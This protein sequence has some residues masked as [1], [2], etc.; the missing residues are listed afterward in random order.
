MRCAADDVEP[1]LPQHAH[2]LE[3]LGDG[4]HAVIEAGQ[5]VAVE[6]DEAHGRTI[7]TQKAAQMHDGVNTR[8]DNSV[9]FSLNE[10]HSLEAERIAEEAAEETA[11]LVAI[12]R[13]R[14]EAEAQAREVVETERLRLELT[15]KVE[16]DTRERVRREA[17]IRLIEAEARLEQEAQARLEAAR[18]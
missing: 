16:A 5:D 3:R 2:H 11:R 13:A 14:K 12:E 15:A 9:L 8:S 10:L 4:L 1:E 6:V 7:L 18:L 17:E